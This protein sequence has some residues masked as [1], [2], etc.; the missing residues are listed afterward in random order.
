MNLLIPTE[1]AMELKES[2]ESLLRNLV[3]RDLAFVLLITEFGEVDAKAQLIGNC[4]E[5]G[6]RVLVG[7]LLKSWEKSAN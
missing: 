1:D 3:G 5:E 4:Q 7:S 6:V 2:L